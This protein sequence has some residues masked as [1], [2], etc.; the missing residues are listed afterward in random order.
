M[1]R[2]RLAARWILT[3]LFVLASA[4]AFAHGHATGN[5]FQLFRGVVYAF[6]ALALMFQAKS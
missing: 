1:T 6:V 3:A 4:A 5:E 2:A